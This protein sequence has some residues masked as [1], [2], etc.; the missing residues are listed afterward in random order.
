MSEKE[1]DPWRILD[2]A[3]GIAGF[4][5]PEVRAPTC[6][7]TDRSTHEGVKAVE[8]KQYIFECPVC[9]RLVPP[10]MDLPPRKGPGV[11]ERLA[12]QM[13]ADSRKS[14]PDPA[15]MRWLL[16]KSTTEEWI[17]GTA[18]PVKWWERALRRKP[19]A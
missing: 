6:Y 5:P 14:D 12:E 8:V 16:G 1:N 10:D 19:R 2:E 17:A 4:E 3:M 18:R 9:K 13:E 7:G 11:L 15:T